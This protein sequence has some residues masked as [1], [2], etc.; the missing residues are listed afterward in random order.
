MDGSGRW[1][2][3]ELVQREDGQW[4]GN[5]LQVLDL[6]RELPVRVTLLAGLPK[7]QGFDEVVRQTTELGVSRIIPVVAIAPSSTPALI[8]CNAGNASLRKRRNSRNDNGFPH[9]GTPVVC[10]AIEAVARQSGYLC[11]ARGEV[12]SFTNPVTAA[13]EFSSPR[14]GGDYHR[15]WLEGVGLLK[16]CN[17]L[18]RLIGNR[19]PSGGGF[20]ELLRL[21]LWLWR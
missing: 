12:R 5:L 3:T 16:K 14:Y 1:W 11:V 7:G 10:G 18:D 4:Q 9:S 19:C 13:S 6:N 15:H 20:C 21:R 17:R 2:E 8:S